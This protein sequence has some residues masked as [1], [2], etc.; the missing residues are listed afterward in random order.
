MARRLHRNFFLVRQEAVPQDSFSFLGE[1]YNV[2]CVFQVWERRSGQRPISDAPLTTQD[3]QFVAKPEAEFAFQR[4]GAR[5]GSIHHDFKHRSESS[6][7][8][9]RP[10]PVLTEK[11]LGVLSGVNW[12]GIRARTAGNP[13]IAKRELVSAYMAHAAQHGELVGFEVGLAA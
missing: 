12:E 6:H 5:A 1:P 4:V 7:Y 2:P 9:I 11:V 3:F 10:L 8:F 13:S